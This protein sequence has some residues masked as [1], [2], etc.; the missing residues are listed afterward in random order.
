MWIEYRSSCCVH[1]AV[2]WPIMSWSIQ[3]AQ[4]GYQGLLATTKDNQ[5]EYEEKGPFSWVYS[6][7]SGAFA[8][9]DK[10]DI[11]LYA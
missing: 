9:C 11:R 5:Q 1:L 8:C 2:S 4:G 7:W 3:A 10:S 6:E